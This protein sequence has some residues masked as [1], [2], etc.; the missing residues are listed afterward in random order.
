MCAAL[1]AVAAHAQ[2]RAG[3][4]GVVTDVNGGVVPGATVT[5]TSNETNFSFSAKSSDSGVYTFSSL[6]PGGYKVMVEKVGFSKKILND[7]RVDAEQLRSLN[8]QL[9]VGQVTESVTVAESSLPLMETE[10][11]TVGGTLTSRDVENLPAFGRDPFQLV[12]LAPG[13]F[14]DGAQASSG[15][16]T[17]MPGS[18]RPSAGAANSIFFLENAPQITANG[19]RPNSNN[20]QVDGVGINSVSWGG[21][22][23]LTPNE[24]SIKAQPPL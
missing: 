4:Q 23:V 16:T 21:S 17:T 3:I 19:T 20:I 6:A 9:D 7:V 5:L 24:E 22:A 18:N 15:G 13:V 14:G 1:L 12:R 10:E 8:V 11:P 2:Y